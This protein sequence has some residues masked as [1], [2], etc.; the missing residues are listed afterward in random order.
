[1]LRSKR[2]SMGLVLD[3]WCGIFAQWKELCAL[4]NARWIEL[5][6]ENG[7]ACFGAWRDH[8]LPIIIFR[9]QRK[10]NMLFSIIERWRSVTRNKLCSHGAASL[11]A[12]HR[13]GCSVRV[14]LQ[15]WLEAAHEKRELRI[16]LQVVSR[17]SCK[18]Q[19]SAIRH[20][21]REATSRTFL[22]S[23]EGGA[24]D[25]SNVADDGSDN[26][27]W[28]GEIAD[29]MSGAQLAA[30]EVNPTFCIVPTIDDWSAGD[31][32][33]PADASHDLRAEEQSV[34]TETTRRSDFTVGSRVEV[35]YYGTWHIGTINGLPRDARDP[36]Y[37]VQCDQDPEG[38]VTRSAVVREL[39]AGVGARTDSPDLLQRGSVETSRGFDKVRFRM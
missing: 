3:L 1:M 10:V 19:I 39:Q 8:T 15:A 33:A 24:L 25:K 29:Q 5:A 20:W 37:T 2:K 9:Q 6:L 18:R 32:L 11:F 13:F 12:L 27:S 30:P 34:D 31:E 4:A 36:R 23:F 14:F 35:E 38:I 26:F 22:K 7:V 28:L 21:H 16:T 17:V